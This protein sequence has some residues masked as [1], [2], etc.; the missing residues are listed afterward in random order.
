MTTTMWTFSTKNFTV[1]WHIS[2]CYD[3]D[4]S[5]DDDGTVREGLDDGTLYAFDSE[6]VVY[7]RGHRIASDHLGQNIY[8]DP[9]DFR[10]HIGRNAR[11]HGSYFSDMVRQACSMA[12]Q[13][14]SR[15]PRMRAAV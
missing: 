3:L 9:A 6:M 4:L 5:W 15:R 10:D 12:R 2:D 7:W 13:E 1:E 8:S 14:L 11:G